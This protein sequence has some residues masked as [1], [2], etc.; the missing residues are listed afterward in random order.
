MATKRSKKKGGSASASNLETISGKGWEAAKRRTRLGLEKPVSNASD[1]AVRLKQLKRMYKQ[2]DFSDPVKRA[3]LNIYEYLRRPQSRQKIE[4]WRAG[5]LV[6]ELADSLNVSTEIKEWVADEGRK[7]YERGYKNWETNGKPRPPESR[8]AAALRRE[9]VLFITCYGNEQKR[10]GAIDE[11]LEVFETLYRFISEVLVSDNMPC[12]ATQAILSYHLGS[13]RRLREE[14]QEAEEMYLRALDFYY[15]RS[16]TRPGDLDEFFFITRRV[17]MCVGLGLGWINLTRS[18]LRRAGHALATARALLAQIPDPVVRSFVDM[19]YGTINRVRAGNDK[20]EL[21]RAIAML[22]RARDEFERHNHQRYRMRASYELALAYNL[23]GEFAEAERLL[24]YIEEHVSNDKWKAN[25]HI[26]RSRIRRN[27]DNIADALTEAD[28]ALTA[29]LSSKLKLPL[30][31]AHITMGE[32]KFMLAERGE[33]QEATYAEALRDFEKARVQVQP[34]TGGEA[35]N[36]KILA[37]C[38]LRIAHCHVRDGRW[39]EANSHLKLWV[40]LK[41][42]IEHGWVL[43]V[44]AAQ[45]E[46]EFAD[47][48]QDFMI[49]ASDFKKWDYRENAERLQRWLLA[50][51]M[52]HTNNDTASAAVLLG[53]SENRVK[54]LDRGDKP[55]K[56]RGHVGD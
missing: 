35:L 44:L 50:Q 8:E 11:A 40:E 15:K 16:M 4:F 29:A 25:L 33:S 47:M 39:K 13:I 18:Y 10:K 43:D 28:L 19:L 52:R 51:A 26:L 48:T 36:Q 21:Q 42:H 12:N 30:A 2:G 55:K 54:Q 38:L 14:H 32:A 27:D 5:T 3:C 22:A 46:R 56:K 24:D 45:V 17:A 7:L 1:F 6:Y 53:Y 23:T 20:V 41:P 31:D 37:V 9:H 34:E 49:S